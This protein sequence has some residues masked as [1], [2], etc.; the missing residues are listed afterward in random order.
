M[1]PPYIYKNVIDCKVQNQVTRMLFNG[2]ND[3]DFNERDTDSILCLND[4]FLVRNFFL[5]EEESEWAGQEDEE[6]DDQYEDD[7]QGEDEDW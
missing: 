2:K 7:D 5:F 1:A 6:D 4:D 3:Q